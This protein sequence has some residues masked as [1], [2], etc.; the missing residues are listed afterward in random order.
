[1][2][3]YPEFMLVNVTV[4]IFV[5][6]VEYTSQVCF[7]KNKQQKLLCTKIIFNH[8]IRNWNWNF[9]RTFLYFIGAHVFFVV[10]ILLIVIHVLVHFCGNACVADTVHDNLTEISLLVVAFW[11]YTHCWEELGHRNTSIS[12]GVRSP[13]KRLKFINGAPNKRQF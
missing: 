13:A 10:S 6:R 4:A 2:I 3:N 9:K 12:A 11:L 5:K 1:M 7:S 8:T